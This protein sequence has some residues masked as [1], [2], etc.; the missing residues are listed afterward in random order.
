MTSGKFCIFYCSHL[1]V[2]FI[3]KITFICS[4]CNVNKKNN[5]NLKLSLKFSVRYLHNTTICYVKENCICFLYI[6]HQ[7]LIWYFSLS[8]PIRSLLNISNTCSLSLVLT[9][10]AGFLLKDVSG[11]WQ[12]IIYIYQTAKEDIKQV[13][14]FC[15]QLSI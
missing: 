15:L 10:L 3:F 8:Q 11:T 12:L 2:I 6:L 4:S 7:L 14:V 5:K 13:T 9:Q 1:A